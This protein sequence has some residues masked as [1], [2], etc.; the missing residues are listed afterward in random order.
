MSDAW[1]PAVFHHTRFGSEYG[2]MSWPQ[3]ATLEE[4]TDQPGDLALGSAFASWRQHHPGGNAEMALEIAQHLP[5]PDKFNDTEH[6]DTFVY[7]SQV[8]GMGWVGAVIPMGG[9]E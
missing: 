6:F 1:N 7:F 3:R 5:L 4:A 2:F 8:S 9:T